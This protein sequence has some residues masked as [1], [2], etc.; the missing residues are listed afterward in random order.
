MASIQPRSNPGKFADIIR[1]RK[2]YARDRFRPYLEHA[3]MRQRRTAREGGNSGR[4]RRA[5]RS[6]R[7]SLWRCGRYEYLSGD[8]VPTD[9]SL[10]NRGKYRRRKTDRDVLPGGSARLLRRVQD[11]NR[12]KKLRAW[13]AVRYF[14]LQHLIFHIPQQCDAPAGAEVYW[15][16]TCISHFR[17]F[18]RVVQSR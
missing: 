3:E 14:A 11:L 8:P 18:Q 5:I 6:L 13:D 12:D 10:E 17:D 1:A 15:F 9:I 2:P 7:I 4:W 16:R